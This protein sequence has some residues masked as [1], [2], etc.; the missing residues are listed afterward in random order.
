[1]SVKWKQSFSSGRVEALEGM[2]VTLHSG[3]NV[4][5]F[6]QLCRRNGWDGKFCVMCVCPR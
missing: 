6:P 1:M 5:G 2:V 3:G 4:P